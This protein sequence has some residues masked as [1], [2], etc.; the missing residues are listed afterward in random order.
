MMTYLHLQHRD[1]EKTL[2][3][4]CVA[5]GGWIPR[6]CSA[7]HSL[8]TLPAQVQPTMHLHSDGSCGEVARYSGETIHVG[9]PST[10]AGLHTSLVFAVLW[11]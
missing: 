6:T 2:C 7:W 4:T 5:P 3:V 9:F 1:I 8:G 10:L 11:V